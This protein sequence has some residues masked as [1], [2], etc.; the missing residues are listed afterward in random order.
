MFCRRTFQ[1]NDRTALTPLSK[2]AS[3]TGAASAGSLKAA[4]VSVDGV[5]ASASISRS[6]KRMIAEA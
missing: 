1:A 5:A 3:F 2:S 6:I 4:Y